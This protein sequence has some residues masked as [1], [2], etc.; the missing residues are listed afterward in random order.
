M[1]E[2]LVPPAFSNVCHPSPCKNAFPPLLGATISPKQFD[3]PETARQTRISIVFPNANRV[4]RDIVI[5]AKYILKW[6]QVRVLKK[7]L[8]VSQPY[9]CGLGGEIINDY[10]END[11]LNL[12][13][14]DQV[15]KN[16]QL[17]APLTAPNWNMFRSNN[18]VLVNFTQPSAREQQSNISPSLI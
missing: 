15:L 13:L 17:S 11:I 1:P 12:I 3:S 6:I 5:S 9:S 14:T 18:A 10:Q 8:V 2:L 7:V 4:E 16:S